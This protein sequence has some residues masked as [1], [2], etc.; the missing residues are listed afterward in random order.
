MKQSKFA[1][2]LAWLAVLLIAA[3]AT[4]Q[5]VGFPTFAVPSGGDDAAIAVAGQ[6]SRG[7]NT[8]SGEN[9]AF[10]A[11]V[12][13]SSRMVSFNVAGGSIRSGVGEFTYGAQVALH[14]V[15]N[16]NDDA[17]ISLQGGA[18][19]FAQSANDDNGLTGDLTVTNFPIG[20][21][22]EVQPG[23][24]ARIWMMPRL[25]WTQTKVGSDSLTR[26]DFGFSVGI[27]AS[28]ENG[29]GM[30]AAF[31]FADLKEIVEDDVVTSAAGTP[32]VAA[33]GLH[34]VFGT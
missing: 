21:A 4:G 15:R 31:D 1:F 27:S 14:L 10:G 25:N 34:Y 23:E 30:H 6:F 12:I 5:L 16:S 33:I 24:N 13:R 29:W 19:Y 22:F 11:Y 2:S 32:V 26:R 28:A 20:L 3:P 9:N 8:D 7:L 18:G 17:T